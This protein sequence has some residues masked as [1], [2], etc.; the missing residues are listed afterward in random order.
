MIEVSLCHVSQTV[1]IKVYLV[2]GN[3]TDRLISIMIRVPTKRYFQT[4][5]NNLPLTHLLSQYDNNNN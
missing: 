4:G 5:C 1:S 3:S 2:I